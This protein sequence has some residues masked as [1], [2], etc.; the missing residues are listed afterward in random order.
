M[1]P[2]RLRFVALVCVGV[3]GIGSLLLGAK[4]RQRP[5]VVSIHLSWEYD[6][7]MPASFQIDRSLD[8]GHTWTVYQTG[9]AP[10]ARTFTDT[11]PASAFPCYR[12]SAIATPPGLSSPPSP[13]ACI[14]GPGPAPPSPRRR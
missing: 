3:V 8:K 6:G 9:V 7:P 13:F 2:L 4:R 12:V 11:T 14:A 10:T 5:S 1:A